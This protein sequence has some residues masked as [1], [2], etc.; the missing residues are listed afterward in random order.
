M[1]MSDV[2]KP[3]CRPKIADGKAARVTTRQKEI[4]PGQFF[5]GYETIWE[6]AQKEVAYQTPKR[7]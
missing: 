2:K 7:P 4:V 5:V 1:I 6:P 3:F